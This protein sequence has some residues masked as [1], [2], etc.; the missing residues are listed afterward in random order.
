MP[1]VSKENP[2]AMRDVDGEDRAVNDRIRWARTVFQC[3]D[4]RQIGKLILHCLDVLDEERYLCTFGTL[5]RRA[6]TITEG[7]DCQIILALRRVCS[8]I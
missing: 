5:R 1:A 8:P 3:R 2:G 6:F 7:V 4:G